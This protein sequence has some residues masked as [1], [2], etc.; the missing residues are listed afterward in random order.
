MKGSLSVLACET[1]TTINTYLVGALG[2]VSELIFVNGPEQCLEEMCSIS[3]SV[4]IIRL[5]YC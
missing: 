3:L 4:F 2:R 5:A 1:G